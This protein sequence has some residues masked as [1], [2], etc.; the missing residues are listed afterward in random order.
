MNAFGDPSAA[1]GGGGERGGDGSDSDD[2]GGGAR[3]GARGARLM[4]EIKPV[5]AAARGA[6]D[7]RSL[8]GFVF[9]APPRARTM[10]GEGVGM[11]D[12]GAALALATTG[13][14]ETVASG[15]VREVLRKDERTSGES[16][17]AGS[18]SGERERAS[19]SDRARIWET[20]RSGRLSPKPPLAGRS[21]SRGFDPYDML[22]AMVGK[23]S[24]EVTDIDSVAVDRLHPS[25]PPKRP[26]LRDRPTSR[27]SF[28]TYSFTDLSGRISKEIPSPRGGHPGSRNS[29]GG[30]DSQTEFY[31]EL[32][33][34]SLPDTDTIKPAKEFARGI[35]LFDANKLS[36]SLFAFVSAAVNAVHSED[37][38]ARKCAAYA[39]TCKILR[40]CSTIL[41]A[42]ASECAR[43]TRHL[44]ELD[45]LEDRHRRACLRFGSAKNF[46]AGNTGVA[47][48]MIRQLTAMSPSS[49]T[50]N[51]E[52]MLAQCTQ[53]GEV[54]EDVPEDE[55]PR[56]MCAATL[57]S[58][59]ITSNGIV[60]GCCDALH[61]T[62]AAFE[63]GQC[64]VCRSTL[65]GSHRR[66]SHRRN[67][68]G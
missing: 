60:C 18:S 26:S 3:I 28:S 37:P 20:G 68:H 47:A 40:D 49:G 41:V 38:I 58:I 45:H 36:D 5:S 25:S 53:R 54:N 66:N 46:K 6:N 27:G 64:V 23:E 39:T 7:G 21:S 55:D 4:I 48:R 24:T 13:G 34:I 35:A 11:G 50:T 15:D 43:L 16:D 12:F 52:A 42:N 57:E 8:E 33:Q 32:A 65:A 10:G 62:K 19:T 22:D 2:D 51:L 31:E 67:S 56:K 29:L 9:D 63:T 14:E 44:V 1:S 17:R 30:M 59:P 61:S